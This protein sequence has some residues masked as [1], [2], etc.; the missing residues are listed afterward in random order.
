LILCAAAITP[1]GF[2]GHHVILT[3]P[4]PHLI[5]ASAIV[6]AL[7]WMRPRAGVPGTVVILSI[8][9][10]ALA[11]NWFTA[12]AH[13][14]ALQATGG[15]NNFSDAIYDAA[16]DLDVD[17]AG[18]PVVVLDWGLHLP[19]V[20]LSQGRIHSVEVLDGS[21]E[22]LQPFFEDARTRYVAHVPAATNMVTGRQAFI[23]AAAAEGLQP[24]RESEYE[25]R[26]GAPVIDVYVVRRPSPPT[27]ELRR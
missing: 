6:A 22:Q 3:Y 23:N 19:L 26:D 11:Q 4:F 1:G 16:R 13:V 17:A 5:A 8:S 2:A 9:G 14:R 24:V 7:R 10:L 27:A 21:P 15:T 20:G 18:A 12:D 25:T